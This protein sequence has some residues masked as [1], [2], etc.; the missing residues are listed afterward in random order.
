MNIKTTAII[1]I[2]NL[3]FFLL[4]VVY[5]YQINIKYMIVITVSPLRAIYIVI[6]KFAIHAI[7]VMYHILV[8]IYFFQNSNI[9]H[10]QNDVIPMV[11]E[12]IKS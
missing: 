5:K 11:E 3:L 10:G 9:K 2:L 12:E 1:T 8:G 6:N 4:C 7:N